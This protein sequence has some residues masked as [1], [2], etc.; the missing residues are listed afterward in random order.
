[1]HVGRLIAV[2]GLDD[3]QISENYHI[4]SHAPLLQKGALGLVGVAAVLPRL[5][6]HRGLPPQCVN[7]ASSTA[8]CDDT[9][10]VLDAMVPEQVPSQRWM[11]K[12]SSTVLA[13]G[14]L[15]ATAHLLLQVEKP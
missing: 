1:M 4:W 8:L 3:N 14:L 5:V 10:T 9:S 2:R 7:A 6:L 12:G 15:Y 11:L 13:V